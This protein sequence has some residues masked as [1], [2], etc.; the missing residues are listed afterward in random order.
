MISAI[1]DTKTNKT[2]FGQNRGITSLDDVHPELKK[3]LP[4]E[5]LEKWSEYNCAECDAMNQALHDGAS[6]DDLMD[7]HTMKKDL[8]GNYIDFERCDNCKVTF[9]DKKPTSE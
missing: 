4:E 9:G 6:W 2:Y 1:T 8:D 3:H 7:M 5:T